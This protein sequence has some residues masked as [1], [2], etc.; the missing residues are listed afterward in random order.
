MVKKKLQKKKKK[1]GKKEYKL[2]TETGLTK[3]K[4]D[5]QP[6]SNKLICY[7]GTNNL[8]LQRQ[9]NWIYNK[10]KLIRFLEINSF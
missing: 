2:L 4:L 10:F 6:N 9:F 8:L 7:F 1:N 5:K 3:E